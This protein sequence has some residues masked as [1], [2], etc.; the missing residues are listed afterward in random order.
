MVIVGWREWAALPQ[1]GVSRIRAKIDTGA[2]TSSLHVEAQWRMVEQGA[3]WV[4]FA[5]RPHRR[6]AG[7]IEAA[8]P[9]CD[10]RIVTDSGGNRSLRLFVRT[11]LLLAGQT[12]EIDINLTNRREMLFPLLIGRTALNSHCIVDP[13][14]SFIHGRGKR[15]ST[16]NTSV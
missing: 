14:R 8:A 10:E 9:I 5:L 3:P 4:A 6:S 16:S 1:F 2:R 13:Q 12:R 11:A 15:V 7:M